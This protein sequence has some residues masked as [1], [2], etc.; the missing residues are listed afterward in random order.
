[1]RYYYVRWECDV[2]GFKYEAPDSRNATPAGWLQCEVDCHFVVFCPN[3]GKE[4][5][6]AHAKVRGPAADAPAADAPA[7]DAPAAGAP[8][9]GAPQALEPAA[10]A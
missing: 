4:L 2:C 7:A 8:A 9:A 1:M 10:G 5:R 6:A 3:H